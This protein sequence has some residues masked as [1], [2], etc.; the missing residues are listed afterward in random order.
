[1]IASP[2]LAHNKEW[3]LDILRYPVLVTPKID[4]IRA[5]RLSNYT[6]RSRKDKEIPNKY[7]R[8]TILDELACVRGDLDGE[9]IIPGEDFHYTDSIVMSD[10]HAESERFIFCLFDGVIPPHSVATSYQDRIRHE[11][12]DEIVCM[13]HMCVLFPMVACNQKELL[14]ITEQHVREKYEGSIIRSPWGPYKCGRSTER[15]QFM[16]KYVHYE[17]DTAL[18]I[19]INQAMENPLSGVAKYKRLLKPIGRA[20]SLVCTNPKWPKGFNV[21][22]GKTTHEIAKQ[23]WETKSIIGRTIRFKYKPYG[24]KDEPRQATLNLVET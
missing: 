21:S 17:Y 1:M 24:M 11:R 12:F 16:L 9:I 14:A 7:I 4:G 19:G 18:V 6:L 20:G 3:S 2:L 8:E 13:P 22:V 23:W 15:E 10:Q 5:L